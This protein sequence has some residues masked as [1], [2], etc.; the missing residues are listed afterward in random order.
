[1]HRTNQV[2]A[3]TPMKKN[4]PPTAPPTMGAMLEILLCEA[5]AGISVGEE[6]IMN[7]ILSAIA[8]CRAV[9]FGWWVVVTLLA[10]DIEDGFGDVIVVRE[11]VDTPVVTDDGAK[12]LDELKPLADTEGNRGGPVVLWEVVDTRVVNADGAKGLD[13]LKPLAEIE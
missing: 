3:T 2:M 4:R 1:M 5:E 8:I 11:E 9:I 13:E 6:F 10:A 12:G 7:A